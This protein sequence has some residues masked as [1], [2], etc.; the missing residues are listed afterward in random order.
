MKITILV[1]GFL[2]HYVGGAETQS[3]SIARQ[4]AKR[5]HKVTVITRMAP[6]AKRNEKMD[7]FEIRRFEVI[8]F[9]VL[10]LLSHIRN[11]LKEIRKAGNPDVL[12]CMML[13]PNGVVGALAKRKTGMK[14]IVWLRSSYTDSLRKSGLSRWLGNFAIRNADLVLT[15]TEI[16]RK[17]VLEDFPDKNVRAIP[18]G[19]D[20]GNRISSGKG[21]VFVGNF[22]S[23]KGIPYLMEAMKKLKGAKLIMV[24]D[25][26]EMPEAKEMAKGMDVEFVGKVRPEDV[27]KHLARGNIFVS[28]S[29]SGKGEGFPNVIL[30]A[31]SVGL[32]VVATRIAGVPEIIEEGKTGFL[33]RDKNPDELAD[34]LGRLL[35]DEKLRKK[36]SRNCLKAA[37]KYSWKNVIDMLES[38]Y[39]ML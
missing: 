4:L 35:K 6:G 32:P 17:Q 5:G 39:K 7:G 29:V 31:M 38:C 15:Q 11:S 28:S 8:N 27:K 2:P 30:E 13:R 20:P 33:V 1:S 34:R 14:T 21:I 22:I 10:R 24:G 16:V 26:P 12:Q 3:Y 18:N 37:R 9:P 36:M 19:I 23:R 25:G